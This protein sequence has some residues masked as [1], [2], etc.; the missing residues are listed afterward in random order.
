M[1]FKYFITFFVASGIFG[2]SY[3]TEYVFR[4]ID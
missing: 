3:K 4:M 1:K 2:L